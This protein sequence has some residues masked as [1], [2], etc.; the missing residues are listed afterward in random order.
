MGNTWIAV[1]WGTTNFRA[2][3]MNESGVC[4]EEK[5]A[6]L[7]LLSVADKQFAHALKT[8]LGDWLNQTTN[9][10]MAG[11]V[12][13]KQGWIEASYVSLPATLEQFLQDSVAIDQDWA[14]SVKIV[15]GATCINACGQPDVMRGE[16]VQLIGLSR[17]VNQNNFSAILPGTH[18]KHAVWRQG[19]LESFTTYMTGEL[20]SLLKKHSILGLNLVQQSF[21]NPTFRLGVEL[22]YEHSLNNI[23][24]STR[25]NRL[26]EK[27]EEQYVLEYL[28]G[29]LIGNELSHL[30]RG[31]NYYIIGGESLS[32]KYSMALDYLNYQFEIVSGKVCFLEGM[33][34]FYLL[35]LG[36]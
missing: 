26:F 18:S 33:H 30:N 28:S 36:K 10:Y 16:E 25:T 11:M 20:F 17:I 9:I 2:F 1:D 23:L 22:G 32:N 34:Q 13:S 24:F 4:I 35:D 6:E 12:G 14:S 3:L 29:L 7:G 8:Q 21:S 27:V 19:K 15:A 5:S 31:E